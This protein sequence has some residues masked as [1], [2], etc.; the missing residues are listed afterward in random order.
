M[1]VQIELGISIRV[2]YP[3]VERA[4]DSS[5]RRIHRTGIEVVSTRPHSIAQTRDRIFKDDARVQMRRQ[6][7]HTTQLTADR[8]LIRCPFAAC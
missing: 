1:I 5:T 2:S 7:S 6:A 3:Y 4:L 8:K